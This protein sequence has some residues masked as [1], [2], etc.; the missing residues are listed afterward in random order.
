M[1]DTLPIEH[2]HVSFDRPQSSPIWCIQSDE[3]Y[4]LSWCCCTGWFLSYHMSHLLGFLCCLWCL[5]S[6]WA[7]ATWSC[8]P[9]KRQSEKEQTKREGKKLCS[10]VFHKRWLSASRPGYK[11]FPSRHSA[12]VAASSASFFFF[13]YYRRV[14]VNCSPPGRGFKSRQNQTHNNTFFISGH[15]ERAIRWPP[16]SRKSPPMDRWRRGLPPFICSDGEQSWGHG[17]SGSSG[18]GQGG[19]HKCELFLS[20]TDTCSEADVLCAR[21]RV[22][23]QMDR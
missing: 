2:I 22:H 6:L 13:F 23:G 8:S 12:T 5:A 10:K 19:C 18:P 9:Q 20:T 15:R 11:T 16:L 1:L 7:S 4:H 21:V 3:M 17:S 14:A